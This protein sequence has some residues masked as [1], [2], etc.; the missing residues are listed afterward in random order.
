MGCFSWMFSDFNNRKALMIGEKAYLLCPDGSYIEELLYA[1]YGMFDRF[2]VYELV[3]DWNRNYLFEI[4]ESRG[5]HSEIWDEKF[6]KALL[7]GDDSAYLYLRD[8]HPDNKYLLKEWKRELGIKLSCYDEDNESLPF[9]I[10]I[11]SKYDIKYDDVPA[12]K[13]DIY[14]G[15]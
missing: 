8:R 6:C 12:S 2:D 9:P 14:Q 10:K 7:D 13:S 4:L 11:V 3:V 1:G 15:L 5:I